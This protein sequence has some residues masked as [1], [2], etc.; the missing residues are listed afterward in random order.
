MWAFWFTYFA[1]VYLSTV[2]WH[3]WVTGKFAVALGEAAGRLAPHRKPWISYGT[4]GEST[5]FLEDC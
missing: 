4:F 2:F 1:H 5:N 3:C